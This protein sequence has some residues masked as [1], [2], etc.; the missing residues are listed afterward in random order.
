MHEIWMAPNRAQAEKAF[1]YF[2]E[3]YG[4]KYPKAMECLAKDRGMLLTFYVL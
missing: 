3:A 4:A 2:I 1:D